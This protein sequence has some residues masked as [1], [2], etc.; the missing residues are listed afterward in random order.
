MSQNEDTVVFALPKHIDVPFVL[1]YQKNFDE[2]YKDCAHTT[3]DIRVIAFE[4]TKKIGSLGLKRHNYEI[5]TVIMG[6]HSQCPLRLLCP[7]I[8]LRHIILILYPKSADFQYQLIDLNSTTGFSIDEEETSFSMWAN[9]AVFIRIRQ[10][11]F[12]ILAPQQIDWNESEPKIWLQLSNRNYEWSNRQRLSNSSFNISM[13]IEQD[14]YQ[15]DMS[16]IEDKS[17][18]ISIQHPPIWLNE[19]N[20]LNPYARL[21]ILFKHG[22][23]RILLS[24]EMLER[25]I[26]IGRYERCGISLDGS[27]EFNPISRVHCLFI[28]ILGTNYV[29]DT[30]STNGT[31]LFHERITQKKLIAKAPIILAETLIMS[32][33]QL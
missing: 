14:E 19:S 18:S 28:T 12:F 15:Q 8:S 1:L 4:G 7:S 6:R 16:N 26:L 20:I 22:T 9:G 30:A 17:N 32:W 3:D 24:E 10:Y 29:I 23:K 13:P 5:Q 21:D 33:E 11:S 2:I 31:V 25:G 27:T